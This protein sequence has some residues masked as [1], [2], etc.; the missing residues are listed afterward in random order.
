MAVEIVQSKQPATVEQRLFTVDEYY[1]MSETGILKPDERVELIEGVIVK[2]APIGSEH[3]GSVDRL[4]DFIR[5]LLGSM[6]IVRSQNPIH[7]EDGSEPEPDLAIVRRRN[8]YYRVPTV[9]STTTGRSK[10]RCTPG[11]ASSIIGS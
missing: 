4:G 5:S 6:V 8:D 1:R 3:A 7:L 10:V 9:R 2:M 11:P